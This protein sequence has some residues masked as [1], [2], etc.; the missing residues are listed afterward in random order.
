LT[1]QEITSFHSRRPDGVAFDDKNKHCVFLEFTRQMDSVTSSDEGDW[2]EIKE[3]EENERYG[4]YIYFINYLSAL[5]GRPWNCTQA[6]FTVGARGSL[7]KTQFQ[8]R[9]CLLGVTNSKA[10]DKIR[11]LTVSK[12]LALTDIILKLFHVSILHSPERALMMIIAFITFNSSLVP[13]IE[14]LCNS[15]PWEF[16]FSGF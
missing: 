1:S 3:L 9:L 15:N 14:G 16:E 5:Y 6:N 12:T 4:M 10:R 7:K 11:V 8:D 2:A 13:L